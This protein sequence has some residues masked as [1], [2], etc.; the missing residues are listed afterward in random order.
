MRKQDHLPSFEFRDATQYFAL[1]LM[2]CTIMLSRKLFDY[3]INT[4]NINDWYVLNQVAAT[5][6]DGAGSV[7]KIKFICCC[8]L[9]SRTI[10]I[11]V[12]T[13]DIFQRLDVFGAATKVR[14]WHASTVESLQ[15]GNGN[16]AQSVVVGLSQNIAHH[17]CSLSM[18]LQGHIWCYNVPN[19]P[20]DASGDF[21]VLWNAN[22][23]NVPILHPMS[24]RCFCWVVIVIVSDGDRDRVFI[25][26]VITNVLEF[27]L[28]VWR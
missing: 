9:K 27:T 8:M 22:V 10:A 23:D 5:V 6:V 19:I 3:R 12:W 18:L 21:G 4:L 20:V 17:T 14:Q 16:D 11:V 15:N 25:V 28:H 2:A 13:L 26:G 7:C 24:A 1:M